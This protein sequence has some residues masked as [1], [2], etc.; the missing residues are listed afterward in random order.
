[1][2]KLWIKGK[3]ENK[4]LIMSA[5]SKCELNEYC[6]NKPDEELADLCARLKSGEFLVYR[7]IKQL[8]KVRF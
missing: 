4:E 8:K 1:M 7:P 5:C 6:N 2:Y 3:A